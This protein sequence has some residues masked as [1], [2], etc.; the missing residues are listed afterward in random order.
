MPIRI[1][2]FI[3]TILITTTLSACQPGSVKQ[4]NASIE[5]QTEETLS[6]AIQSDEN[7]DLSETELPEFDDFDDF[8]MEFN[9]PAVNG[10]PHETVWQHVRAGFKLESHTDKKALQSQLTWYA[11]HKSYI[12][13]VMKRSDPFLHYILSEAED[14]GLPTELVLLPIV[15]S[16]F[17][18]FAYSHGRA[19]GIWQFIPATGRLYGLKQDWWYDGR[20]DIYTST[21]AALKYLTNLNKLF[22]G[23]W[24]LALAAYNS[25][26]GTVQ[27]A[28]RKNKKRN[29]P[30]DFWSLDLPKE[31]RSYVPKLLALKELISHPQKYEISLRCIPH[32]P[33]FKRVDAGSQIDLALAAELAEIKLDTLYNYNPAYNRWATPPEGPHQLLL[34]ADAADTL[35]ANLENLDDKDRIRWQRHRIESG[36]TL[37]HIA[38]KYDTTVKH[39][40]KVNRIRGNNIRAGKHL[41]IPVASRK[42]TDY[43]LSAGQRLSSI[44]NSS[45][46]KT[47]ITYIVKKGDSFWELSRKY[48]VGMHKLAKWNGMAIRDPLRQG[49]KIVVWKNNSPTQARLS[50]RKPSDTIQSISYTVRNGDSLSRIASRYSVSVNDLHRWNVIKSKYLQPGQRIKVYIDIT[51]QT[52]G[53]G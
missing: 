26:S 45:K 27:R 31:T 30:T 2:Y 12:Q 6:E 49:Q 13:R 39:L 28:I 14:R 44:Q 37:G 25:G 20:R 17:Q 3:F 36:E 5:I 53:H 8:D 23:D 7:Q 18:P 51:E 22:K 35:M 10:L 24:L 15:E 4:D 47:R 48:D 52:G 32:V 1:F 38:L 9:S 50:Q 16:A 40:R 21:Q 33:G 43:A 11:G 46:G 29:K 19:A 34:P 42:R 41:L